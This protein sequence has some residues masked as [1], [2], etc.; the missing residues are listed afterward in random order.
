MQF[1]DL[2]N[3]GTGKNYGI[4]L[5]LERFFADNY[6]FML[7]GTVFNSSY[8]ALDGIERNTPFNSNYLVNALFG[9]EFHELGKKNNQSLSINAKVFFGGGRRTIPLL[10]DNDGA[11]AVD[12]I[13]NIFWDYN[14]AYERRMEDIYFISLAVSY[15]WNKPNVTHELFLNLDNLTNNQARL[16]EFYAPNE[17][18]D[19][20]YRTTF[21][22]F[23][24]LMYRIYF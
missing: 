4:E 24:N 22:L 10:R 16:M 12:P 17:P 19:I 18:E 5:T 3:S 1:V 9:K 15:K 8:T 20:G 21:G 13:N 23:P 2:I 11:L 6:Y 7:N 14:K